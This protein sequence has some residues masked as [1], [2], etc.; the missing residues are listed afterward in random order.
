MQNVKKIEN[1][2]FKTKKL[3]VIKAIYSDGEYSIKADILD[4]E[5]Y[6]F[7]LKEATEKFKVDKD[8]TPRFYGSFEDCFKHNLLTQKEA[9]DLKEYLDKML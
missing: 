4:K 3:N 7:M 2:S 5:Y 6:D 8:F 9:T 1:I